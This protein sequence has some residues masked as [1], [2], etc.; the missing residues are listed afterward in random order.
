MMKLQ[1]LLEP[2]AERQNFE[3]FGLSSVCFMS[4]LSEASEV[5]TLSFIPSTSAAF[6]I[7]SQNSHF[8]DE[9]EE[10][11]EEGRIM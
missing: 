4:C 6:C 2:P 7:S 11:E 5:T 3:I 8:S 1:L 10:E 9:E